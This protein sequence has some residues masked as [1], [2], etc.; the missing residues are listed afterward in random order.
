MVLATDCQVLLKH[1][2]ERKNDR[3]VIRT[4]LDEISEL[5]SGFFSF[6]FLYEGR[7]AN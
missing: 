3:S 7:E 1:W 4:I 6:H 5:K 2:V